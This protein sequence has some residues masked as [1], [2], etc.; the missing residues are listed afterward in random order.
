MTRV[1]PHLHSGPPSSEEPLTAEDAWCCSLPL[2]H[3]PAWR[4]IR[5]STALRILLGVP[6]GRSP[7]P[8]LS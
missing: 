1:P 4:L 3:C 8:G 5:D 7:L 2:G 6:G